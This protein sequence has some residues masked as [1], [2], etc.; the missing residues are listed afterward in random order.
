MFLKNHRAISYINLLKINKTF[1]YI[2]KNRENDVIDH[3]YIHVQ[4]QS[5]NRFLL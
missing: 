4:L 2:F 1:K 5:L 3:I